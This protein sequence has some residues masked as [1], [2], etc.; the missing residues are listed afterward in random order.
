MSAV[1]PLRLRFRAGAAVQPDRHHRFPFASDID[2]V[3]G[4]GGV[5]SLPDAEEIHRQCFASV[6]R[7][8][9]AQTLVSARLRIVLA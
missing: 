2:L 4:N 7:C 9:V 3:S 6:I 5:P 8:A 1:L